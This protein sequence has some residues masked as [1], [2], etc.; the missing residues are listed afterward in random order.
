MRKFY[1]TFHCFGQVHCGTC[2]LQTPEGRQWRESIAKHFSVQSVQNVQNV[3]FECPKDK[4]WTKEK[5]VAPA[6]S[7]GLGD[8]AA[9]FIH[10]I[11]AGKIKPCNGC[12]ERQRKLNELIPYAGA[13][14]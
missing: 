6:H 13:R 14:T 3:D 8:T 9:K 7:R 11:T 1:Q 5:P 2:R 12:K 4:P 10:A